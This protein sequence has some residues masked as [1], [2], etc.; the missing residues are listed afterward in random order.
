MLGMS[1]AEVS[2]RA[3]Q[4]LE[5]ED[6]RILQVNEA[7]ISKHEFVPTKGIKNRR[8]LPAGRPNSQYDCFN[9]T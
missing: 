4:E 9:V 5:S 8:N 3:F 1:S 7:A 6:F 2:V